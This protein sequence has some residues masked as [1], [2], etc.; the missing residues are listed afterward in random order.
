M[1]LYISSFFI[2]KNFINIVDD[3][4]FLKYKKELSLLNPPVNLYIDGNHLSIKW[5]SFLDYHH[6]QYEVNWNNMKEREHIYQILDR[7]LNRN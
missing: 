6:V 3:I 4:K 5:E 7:H 2:D 1:G